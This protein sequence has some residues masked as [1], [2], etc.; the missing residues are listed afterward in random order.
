M[1]LKTGFFKEV[2]VM[3]DPIHN[4]IQV[5]LP[6]IW[7]LI[8]APEFQRLRRIHQLSGAYLVFHTAEHSR[9]GHSLG[10]YEIVRRMLN[11]VDDLKQ[12][13]SDLEKLTVMIAGLLHDIGHWPFSHAFEFISPVRHEEMT[14]R[15][16]LGDSEINKI[17]KKYDEKLPEL[18][19]S[20]IDHSHP[21][22]L[23]SQLI[24][25]QLDAD[26]MDYLL[27]DSYF[28]GT[29]YGEFDLERVL[30]TLKVY[31]NQLAVKE[32]G[33]HT[34]EDYIMARYHMYWQVYYHAGIRAFEAMLVLLFRRLKEIR[35]VK[36]YPIF[37]AFFNQEKVTISQHFS[38]DDYSSYQGFYLLKQDN[39]EILS[40]LANRLINRRLFAY[41]DIQIKDNI[42]NYQQLIPG[43]DPNYYLYKDTTSQI[44][45][46][47]YLA[48]EENLI[49]VLNKDN[50]LVELSEISHIVRAIVQG[51]IKEDSKLFY[52]E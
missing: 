13:L 2:K 51:E 15:I 16:I 44:P 37:T 22:K 8:N 26:R 36:D 30:R 21:N 27:R 52:P 35:T 4:Y 7:E 10:T 25:G 39:D 5:R 11:E 9:F 46:R 45:Y 17:L 49:K 31:D 24:S 18:V 23:L 41:Q 33:I 6:L 43:K 1:D 38:F 3:R 20:I 47:P 50:K 29:K 42:N 19:S 40:D 28:T 34:I 32:S 12:Q 48:Q 14:K